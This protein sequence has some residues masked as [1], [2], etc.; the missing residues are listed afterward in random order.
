MNLLRAGG[1]ADNIY[2]LCS[3]IIIRMG[4]LIVK[5]IQK[6]IL[7]KICNDRKKSYISFTNARKVGFIFDAD[8]ENI[9]ESLLILENF[10]SKLKIPF[11]GI[12]VDTNEENNCSPLIQS[13]PHITIIHKTDMNWLSVPSHPLLS[14]FIDEKYDI[15]IDLTLKNVFSIEYIVRQVNTSLLV[16]FNPKYKN[17]YDILIKKID[18]TSPTPLSYYVNNTINYLTTIKS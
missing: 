4:N 15:F 2:Y 7:K 14:K 1:T 13:D 12:S 8:T 3:H 5:L 9:S 11:N 16:G 6:R 18:G 17:L 10:L